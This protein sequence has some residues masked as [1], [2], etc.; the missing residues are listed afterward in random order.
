[1]VKRKE[2]NDRNDK[3]TTTR[4]GGHVR[5]SLS[6]SRSLFFVFLVGALRRNYWNHHFH[7]RSSHSVGFAQDIAKWHFLLS[8]P[9][10]LPSSNSFRSFVTNF[11]LSHIFN[12]FHYFQQ[13]S[14]KFSCFLSTPVKVRPHFPVSRLVSISPNFLDPMSLNVSFS[15]DFL[16]ESGRRMEWIRSRATKR[17]QWIKDRSVNS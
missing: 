10:L 8:L 14:L 5:L 7:V 12:L 9:S 1:M 4:V 16:L 17:L 15:I 3:T 11:L 6:L 2:R 13:I